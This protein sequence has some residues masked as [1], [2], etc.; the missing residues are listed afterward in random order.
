MNKKDRVR[1]R[2][3]SNPDEK[4]NGHEMFVGE[5]E[6]FKNPEGFLYRASRDHPLDEDGY[7]T[8]GVCE[9]TPLLADLR[10]ERAIDVHGP[11]DE[12]PDEMTYEKKISATYYSADLTR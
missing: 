3:C 2:T 7:R 4:S 5:D 6:Y 1:N 11:E 9:A 12:A 8:G 10:I